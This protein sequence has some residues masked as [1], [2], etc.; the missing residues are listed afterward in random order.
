[1]LW[2][3][4]RMLCRVGDLVAFWLKLSLVPGNQRFSPK[5]MC[6]CSKIG[7]KPMAIYS[8]LPQEQRMSRTGL[9]KAFTLLKKVLHKAS[10]DLIKF[11]KGWV[12][13]LKR[14]LR[15]LLSRSNV[16]AH[17]RPASR[18]LPSRTC[19]V[20]ATLMLIIASEPTYLEDVTRAKQI[21]F[22]YCWP[23]E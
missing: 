12:K 18:A 8:F 9:K 14:P 4:Y 5:N 1:M 22:F 11:L 21:S 16:G 13:V 19:I 7:K 17:L 20:I 3:K 10:K 2:M 6:S 23:C 15:V